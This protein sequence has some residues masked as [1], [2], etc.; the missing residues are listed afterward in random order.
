M[1]QASFFCPQCNQMKLFVGE[2]MSHAAHILASVFLCGLWLPIWLIMAATYNPQY[3]CNN[4]GFT[5]AIKYLY[6]P[7]LRT[8][9]AQAAAYNA[10]LRAAKSAEYRATAGKSEGWR[11]ALYQFFAFEYSKHIIVGISIAIFIFALSII[12][13]L[14]KTVSKQSTQNAPQNYSSPQSYPSPQNYPTQKGYTSPT[15][16]YTVTPKPAQSPKP[17]V[18]SSKSAVVISENANLRT[19]PDSVSAIVEVLPSGAAVE[20]IKQKGAWFYVSSGLQ[21]GWIHGN[22]IKLQ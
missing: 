12:G 16:V 18:S 13:L 7:T 6:D 14:T 17:N 19:S 9:Q 4:C 3:R 1:A 15:P 2:E 8:R 11:K 10:Q 22:T 20:V 21:E 5:D